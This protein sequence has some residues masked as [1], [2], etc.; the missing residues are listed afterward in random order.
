MKPQA[1][2]TRAARRTRKRRLPPGCVRYMEIQGK[3]V[4]FAELWMQPGDCSITLWFED[5][6]CLHFDLDPGLS[7][8]TEYNDWKTG[9]QRVIKSWRVVHALSR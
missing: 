4:D 7:V 8:E 6:T 2:E 5:K 1:G 9:Q 3:T